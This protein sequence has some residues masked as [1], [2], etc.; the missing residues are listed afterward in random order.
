MNNEFNS[1]LESIVE[2]DQRYKQ[3]AYDFVMEALNFTQKKFRRSKHVSGIELLDGMRELV[4]QKFGPLTLQ[5]LK[6]WGIHSTEDFGNIVFTLVENRILSKTE[7]D[8]LEHFR[9]VYDFKEV[10]DRGYRKLLEKRI[11][12]MR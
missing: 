1:I 11:S 10:F 6:H 2:G 12:R 5:V 9:N 7:E 8:S 3:D 4:L